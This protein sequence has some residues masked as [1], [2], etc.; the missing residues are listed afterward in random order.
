MP[1]ASAAPSLESDI[2]NAYIAAR[3]DGMS[4]DKV[5]DIILTALALDMS[6]AIHSYMIQAMVTTQDTSSTNQLD[7]PGSGLTTVEGT[8]TG[9]GSLL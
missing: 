8:G 4:G 1:L 2:G 9:V 3:N 5:S 6:M 7:I